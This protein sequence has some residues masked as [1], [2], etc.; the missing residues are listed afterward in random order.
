MDKDEKASRKVSPPIS[1][2]VMFLLDM[3]NLNN[4]ETR[5]NAI[6]LFPQCSEFKVNKCLLY[7]D[8]TLAD[9][10]EY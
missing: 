3:V 5:N 10:D 1:I 9:S 2:L 6:R 7:F 4:F 8:S